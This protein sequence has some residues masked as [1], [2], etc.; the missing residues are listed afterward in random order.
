MDLPLDIKYKIASFN[1]DT[2]LRLSFLDEEFKQFSYGI[3]RKLFIELFTIMREDTM[4]KIW[5]IFN[6]IHREDDK[7]AIENHGGNK[8]WYINGKLHRDNDKPAIVTYDG[9]QYWYQHDKKHRDNN[10]PAI[11]Y[12]SGTKAW[13]QN[14]KLHRNNDLPAIIYSTGRQE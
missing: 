9:D 8:G 12:K 4:G 2:W 14:D 13:Y 5:K 7:P 11:I 6:K 10:K 3:G 1:I